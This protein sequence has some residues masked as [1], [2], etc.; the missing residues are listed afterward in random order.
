[1]LTLLHSRWSQE[2]MLSKNHSVLLETPTINGQLQNTLFSI[3]T[4]KMNTHLITVSLWMQE[5]MVRLRRKLKRSFYFLIL[6]LVKQVTRCLK[7]SNYKTDIFMMAYAQEIISIQKSNQWTHLLKHDD[8]PAP[9]NLQVRGLLGLGETPA[10]PSIQG[11]LATLSDWCTATRQRNV[12]AVPVGRPR[13]NAREGWQRPVTGST[14][15]SRRKRGQREDTEV[16]E[17]GESLAKRAREAPEPRGD[18]AG[19]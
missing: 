3:H 5:Q 7:S 11:S 12:W 19:L 18:Q 10:S 2:L 16:R 13:G 17:C 9:F 14:G 1:M 6:W 15:S 4:D 8:A